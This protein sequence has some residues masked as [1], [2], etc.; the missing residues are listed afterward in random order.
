VGWPV[1]LQEAASPGLPTSSSPLFLSPGP[2]SQVTFRIPTQCA[3]SPGLAF[4]P[5]GD[6]WSNAAA[7]G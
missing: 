7:L 6:G 1:E 4:F 3:L 2:T 5:G